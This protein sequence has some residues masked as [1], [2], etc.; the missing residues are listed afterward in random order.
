MIMK[1]WLF[2]NNLL[3]R[4]SNGKLVTQIVEMLDNDSVDVFSKDVTIMYTAYNVLESS[5]PLS[6]SEAIL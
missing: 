3:V 6:Y 4:L 5:F 1:N 2:L